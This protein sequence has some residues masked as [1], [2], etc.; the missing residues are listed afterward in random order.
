MLRAGWILA[1]G[2]FALNEVSYYPRAAI[3]SGSLVLRLVRLRMRGRRK[4]QTIPA[5]MVIFMRNAC[6]ILAAT[7]ASPAPCLLSNSC[8]PPPRPQV[9]HSCR[10]PTPTIPHRRTCVAVFFGL[11]STSAC[12]SSSLEKSTL[13]KME[14]SIFNVGV[15][16]L[17]PAGTGGEGAEWY[18]NTLF[19][20]SA[21]AETKSLHAR[22][23]LL[24]ARAAACSDHSQVSFYTLQGDDD[25]TRVVYVDIYAASVLTIR[26]QGLSATVRVETAWPYSSEVRMT[27]T[28]S[29]A[30]QPLVLALRMPYWLDAPVSIAVNDKTYPSSG[31]P[32]AHVH[33]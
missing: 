19:C 26:V 24:R 2:S 7:A 22:Q 27:I 21:Q 18:R 15:A 17:G 10:T 1:G 9:N 13:Q 28:M 4:N 23:L 30:S 14:R 33:C 3:L 5:M 8:E 29:E 6:I 11:F 20:Q 31:L 25:N 16:A 32:G 12:I